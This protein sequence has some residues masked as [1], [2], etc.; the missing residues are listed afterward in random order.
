[1]KFPP[2]SPVRPRRRPTPKRGLRRRRVEVGSKRPR[3]GLRL[4]PQPHAAPHLRAYQPGIRSA[5]SSEGTR[6]PGRTPGGRA[7]TCSF[8]LSRR[9]PQPL[10]AY[11]YRPLPPFSTSAGLAQPHTSPT[12]SARQPIQ[13][14]HSAGQSTHHVCRLASARPLSSLTLLALLWFSAAC[15]CLLG[16]GTF[17]R[18]D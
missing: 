9:L 16:Y 17:A 4:R 15:S 7:T 18:Q 14:H 3:A 1:M 8:E 6:K 10:F 12:A 11:P 13:F 5:L 2:S